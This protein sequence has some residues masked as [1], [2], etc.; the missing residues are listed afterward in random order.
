MTYQSWTLGAENW[1]WLLTHGLSI[2]PVAFPA[3]FKQR[4]LLAPICA[5]VH[6]HVNWPISCRL[7]LAAQHADLEG[8]A[9]H[10]QA[11]EGQ[12]DLA[13]AQLA[14]AEERARHAS[15]GLALA[16]M[17]AEQAQADAKRYHSTFSN[18]SLLTIVQLL[19]ELM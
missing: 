1:R 5:V 2:V 16:E 4:R 6:A 9:A 11:L 7:Q 10:M 18:P 15:S 12:L 14:A 17:T 13:E 8:H 19:N 3:E